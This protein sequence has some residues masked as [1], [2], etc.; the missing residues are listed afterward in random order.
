LVRDDNAKSRSRQRLDLFVP[1]IPEFRETVQKNHNRT[2][3][4]TV[5]DGLQGYVAVLK[6]E[7]VQR[8]FHEER[9]YTRQ[10]TN[11][12]KSDMPA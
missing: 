11:P 8:T 3:F 7:R 10:R 4:R 6:D 1:P 2:V 9:V 5:S 12:G